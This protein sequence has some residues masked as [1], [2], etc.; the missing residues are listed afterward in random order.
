MAVA[1][2]GC[3]EAAVLTPVKTIHRGRKHKVHGRSLTATEMSVEYGVGI[4][5]ILYRLRKGLTPEEATQPVG[6]RRK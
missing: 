5:T 1:A 2:R 3:D 6:Y 4:T